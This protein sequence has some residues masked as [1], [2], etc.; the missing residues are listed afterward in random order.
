MQFVVEPFL[1]F[2]PMPLVWTY[3]AAG[4]EV[5]GAIMLI[6]GLYTRLASLS[7]TSTMCAPCSALRSHLCACVDLRMSV[8][9]G[10]GRVR[11][12]RRSE[13]VVVH[14]RVVP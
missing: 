13:V 11:P 4:V 2:L 6:I 5:V 9:A 10:G 3:A 7:L 1:G 14:D 8:W 12:D